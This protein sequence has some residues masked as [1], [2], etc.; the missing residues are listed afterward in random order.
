MRASCAGLNELAEAL[1]VGLPLA[2]DNEGEPLANEGTESGVQLSAHTGHRVAAFAADDHERAARCEPRAK[3]RDRRVPACVD[4]CVIGAAVI[5]VS[6]VSYA[7]TRSAPSERTK[8]TF[9]SR[10]T[11][12]TCAPTARAIWTAKLPTPPDA[13]K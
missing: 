11:P 12:V 1:E 3:R 2:V 5:V 10:Q 8:S 4:D 7:I 13:P 6:T 9:V